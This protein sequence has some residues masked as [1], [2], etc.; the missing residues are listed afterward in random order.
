MKK[1]YILFSILLLV[2]PLSYATIGDGLQFYFD[3]DNFDN[4]TRVNATY[5]DYWIYT[6]GT[7]NTTHKKLGAS[8]L[9]FNYSTGT[10]WATSGWVMNSTLLNQSDSWTL[11]FWVYLTET[12][13][14]GSQVYSF[15]RGATSNGTRIIWGS[16]SGFQMQTFNKSTIVATL[17][18]DELS[19]NLQPSYGAWHHVMVS[20]NRTNITQYFYFN[21]RLA[22]WD[23]NTRMIDIGMNNLMRFGSGALA[24]GIDE[25]A[26]WNRTL[27][28]C[29]KEYIY[30]KS[31]GVFY[32]ESWA[33][34][35]ICDNQPPICPASSG[36]VL[37]QA[38][39]ATFGINRFSQNS[40]YTN[41]NGEETEDTYIDYLGN[42]LNKR[43]KNE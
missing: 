16:N 2:I 3:L 42:T 35:D 31:T 21:G 5:G 33:T 32:N 4:T 14:V 20:Y 28:E 40:H 6:N 18:Y 22:N 43:V 34:E 9:Y 11:S 17:K 24:F 23:N 36:S 15:I 12:S 30:N 27:S 25:L 38:P 41:E 26:W 1:F 19:G 8:S 29:E 13:T 37:V 10:N 7:Q 39:K